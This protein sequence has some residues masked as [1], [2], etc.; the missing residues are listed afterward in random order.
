M[1]Y[2]FPSITCRVTVPPRPNR[3]HE[4]AC[5]NIDPISDRDA[6]V[7]WTYSDADNDVQTNYQ[8]EVATR[9]D[10]DPDSIVKRKTAPANTNVATVRNKLIS[11]L[12]PN[13]Q[14][15]VRIRAYNV[16]N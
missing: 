10:F 4:V 13:T 3:D 5:N 1:T 11:D 14:Y 6:Q 16:A 9:S 12:A 2:S 8:I 15:Y 7:N